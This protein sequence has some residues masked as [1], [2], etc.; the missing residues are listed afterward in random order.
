M[1]WVIYAWFA[2]GVFAATVNIVAGAN[3]NRRVLRS[4]SPQ[5]RVTYGFVSLIIYAAMAWFAHEVAA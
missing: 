5:A 2:L 1:I 4:L 3:G